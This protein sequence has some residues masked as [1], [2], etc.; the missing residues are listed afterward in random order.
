MKKLFLILLCLP[1]MFT[2]CK[3]EEEENLDSPYVGYWSGT[4]FY[5]GDVA[6]LWSAAISTNGDVNGTA[7]NIVG[8]ETNLNGTVTTNG[9]FTATLVE[10]GINFIGQLSSDT[11]SGIWNVDTNSE[12]GTWDLNKE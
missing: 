2:S 5:D 4:Y 7:L 9:Y 8:E 1:L 6:G 3:K 12:T 11:G 10:I